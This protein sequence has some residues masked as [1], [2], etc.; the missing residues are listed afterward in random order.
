AE[1]AACGRVIAEQ[2]DRMT[3]VA[4]RLLG[5][6]RGREQSRGPVDLLAVAGQ[7]LELVEPLAKKARVSLVLADGVP[8]FAAIDEGAFHHVLTTLTV[9]G[10]HAMRRGG[11]PRVA[12]RVERA[13]PPADRRLPRGEYA[14]IAILDEGEGIPEEERVRLF[15]PFFTTK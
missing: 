5:F 13:R 7:A 12:V 15:E 14:S 3:T 11:T 4:R 8:T 6:A 10:I 1:V 2:A 9:N